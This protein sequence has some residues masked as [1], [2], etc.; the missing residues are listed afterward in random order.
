MEIL[1]CDN[2]DDDGVDSLCCHHLSPWYCFYII[3]RNS[4]M[5][6]MRVKGWNVLGVFITLRDISFLLK[7]QKGFVFHPFVGLGDLS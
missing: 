6:A 5:I 2:D 1:L 4:V 3:I 7:T